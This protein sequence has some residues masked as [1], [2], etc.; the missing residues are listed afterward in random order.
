MGSLIGLGL[1]LLY[2]G[3]VLLIAIGLRHFKHELSRN[4]VHIMAANW[5]ILVMIYVDNFA[6][7]VASAL[8]FVVI[9]TLNV[10]YKWI[11]SIL[12]HGKLEQWGAVYYSIALFLLA[13]TT[14]FN[15]DLKMVG[16]VGILALGYGDG[17]ASLV[18][19]R[20][21]RHPYTVFKGHKSLEGSLTMGV[22]TMVVLGLFFAFF[23]V[24]LP[25]MTLLSLAVIAMVVEAL[26]P[27]G[28]DNL[29]VPLITALFYFICIF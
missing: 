24:S 10:F 21:G 13:A 3:I 28:L 19:Q 23:K 6:F 5:W 4:F 15:L 11:P 20:F 12:A 26:S 27:Y 17:L 25:F 2:L 16:G 1:S 8:V 22:S 7:V 9:N 18:G 29:F 14:Y